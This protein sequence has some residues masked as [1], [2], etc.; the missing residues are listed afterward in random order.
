MICQ[1]LE[2]FNSLRFK[3]LFHVKE[4]IGSCSSYFNSMVLLPDQQVAPPLPPTEGRFE[5]VI[6][7]DL[8]RRLD[9]SPVEAIAGSNSPTS[10]MLVHLT[11]NGTIP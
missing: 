10:G 5:I 2:M 6:N 11:N 8:I 4:A 7:N 3:C 9:L 1:T